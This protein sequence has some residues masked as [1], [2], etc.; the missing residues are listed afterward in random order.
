MRFREFVLVVSAAVLL[1]TG[2]AGSQPREAAGPAASLSVEGVLKAP[3][4]AAYSPPAFSPDNR[5][6]A[7]VVT[8]HARRRDAV[9]SKKLLRAGVAWYGIASD[10]W[11]SDL[12]TGERRNLTSGTGH[13]W[14]PSWSPDGRYLA[15]LSDR[16][17]GPEVGPARLWIWERS[18]GKLRQASDADVREGYAGTHWASDDRSVLVSLFPEDLGRDGYAARME[19]KDSSGSSSAGGTGGATA[20]I[21]EFDP[22]VPDAVPSTDQINLDLWRRDLGLID[23][24]TGKLRRLATSIR[25]SHYAISPDRRQVAY[26]VLQGAEKPGAGQ[27][28]HKIVVQDLVTAKSRVVASDVFLEL[29]ADSFSWSPASDRVAWRTAGPSAKDE[30]HVV[31]AAGGPVR[32]IAQIPAAERTPF[33]VDPPVWDPAGKSVFFIREGVLWRALTDGSSAAAFANS[34]GNELQIL[35]P[36]QHRLFSP[37]AGKSAVVLSSNPSSK[38]VGFARVDLK[39]GAVSPIFEEDK[40]YGGYGNEPTISPDGSRIAYVVEGPLEPP[41]IFVRAGDLTQPR[42]ASQVAPALAGRAFG[43][44][45]VIE[46]HGIDGE[47]QRGALVFPSDYESGKSYPLIVKVYGG[48]SISN[49]LNRFGYAIAPVENLQIFATRGYALL[50]AD[51]KLNVGSPMVD[52]MKTVMPGI[53]KAVESGLADPAR[54]GVT[55]HSYGGYSTLSLIAQS[56]RFKAAVMRAGMGNLISGYGHLAPD[57]TNYGLAWSESGQGRM[58]GSPWEFRE[59]YLENS[60]I[61]YLNRIE[62]PLLIIHGEK[63]DAVPAFLADELFTGLRRLGKPVTYARYE[64]EGHWEGQWSYANQ[65]DCLSRVIAWFDRHLKGAAK[66]EP[67]KSPRKAGR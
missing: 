5:F 25:I 32:R 8:D 44:A 23:V 26:S 4:L 40:R 65:I 48:S 53:N 28:L 50:L 61:F 63:D 67:D 52:L 33:E 27:Y 30:I 20:K 39:S 43:K 42:R 41:D 7:Y 47:K 34:A 10:I 14:A 60:P 62:T 51:S 56:P 6:L 17:A 15:F 64:G 38:R 31:A 54:I 66:S 57:G 16:S 12:E 58:G 36:R 55:G 11:L 35:S 21:F 18:S 1:G 19:G 49:D 37:D 2:A 13:S 59:R 45:E 24:Q 9:D 29:I 46:W 22:S 3:T